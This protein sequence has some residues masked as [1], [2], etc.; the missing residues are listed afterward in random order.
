M[1]RAVD[2]LYVHGVI[3]GRAWMALH[4]AMFAWALRHEC[5]GLRAA[6]ETAGLV[7][8]RDATPADAARKWR[9]LYP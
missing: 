1:T 7:W 3:S 4:R 5:P 9:E 2:W 6:W 8:A